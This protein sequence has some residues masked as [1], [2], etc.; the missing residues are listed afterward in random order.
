MRI[1]QPTTRHRPWIGGA[2]EAGSAYALALMALLVLTVLGLSLAAIT[3]MEMLLGAAERTRLK[4]F[5]AAESGLAVATART[6]VTH[7]RRPVTL[8]FDSTP[9][10]DST[11]SP[12]PGGPST[13]VQQ[14]DRLDISAVRPVLEVPCNFCQINGEGTY[15]QAPLRT[16]SHA[17][18]VTATRTGARGER[19]AEKTL[20][21]VIEV[22]PWASM[23]PGAD[24]SAGLER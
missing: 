12:R 17:V 2:S 23:D 11:S 13:P 21:T 3:Q 10:F 14:L 22:Q 9:T 18:T 4:V 5:Y 19:L 1:P 20:S 8:T 7:D 24:A 16:V 15:R 6:L